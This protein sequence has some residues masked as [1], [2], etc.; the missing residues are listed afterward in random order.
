MFGWLKKRNSTP[1]RWF[2]NGRTPIRVPARGE[3]RELAPV[4]SWGGADTTRLNSAH[5]GKVTDNFIN[6]DIAQQLN[7][8]RDRCRWESRNNPL[9]EGIIASH[10]ADVV[11]V[12]GPSLQVQSDG[13][14]NAYGDALERI[15]REKTNDPRQWDIAEQHTLAEM[16]QL[17]VRAWWI[18]GSWLAQKV[19]TRAGFRVNNIAPRRLINPTDKYRANVVMG[20]ERNDY[21]KPIA[22]YIEKGDAGLGGAMMS[23]QTQRIP[24]DQIIHGFIA[25]EAGQAVGVPALA[26]ALQIIADLRDYD[27]QVLDAARAA[28]DYAVFMFTKDPTATFSVVNEEV[29]IKRRTL[30]TLP[31]GYEIDQLDPKQPSASYVDYRKERMRDIGRGV[32]MPLMMVRLDS[33]DHN[34]S[35]A[36]FDGQLYGRMNQ[37][38]EGVVERSTLNPLADE[39]AREAR[40]AKLLP[41]PPKNVKYIWTWDKPPHVDPLK[42]ANAAKV[43]LEAKISTIADE[44]KSQGKD[45]DTHLAQLVAEQKKLAEAGLTPSGLG[46]PDDTQSDGSDQQSIADAVEAALEELE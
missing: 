8:L 33:S 40:L 24:A 17:W 1:V 27:E 16:L 30:S 37:S 42:E 20:V 44:L 39:V 3:E 28:A 31:P 32:S 12:H 14:D 18:D 6:V 35:S 5:W 45:F 4:R 15:W 13:D 46:G 38:F 43:R 25:L 21:G 19:R 2:S 23:G 36:R 26:P 29:E 7:T 10:V 11:G 34:Y 22:Y 9:I 41:T